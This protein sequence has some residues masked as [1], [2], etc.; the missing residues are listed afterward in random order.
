MTGKSGRSGTKHKKTFE[1]AALA[2]NLAATNLAQE[3]IASALKI[4]V[5]TLVKYYADELSSGKSIL[6][7]EA[8][9]G[10]RMKIAEGD[11][12]AII[13]AASAC[14]GMRE[15]QDVNVSGGVEVR[16]II[17]EKNVGKSGSDRG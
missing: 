12:R 10:L 8:V 13:F 14:G 5:E 16:L 6:A 15:K 4:S 11:T 9:E 17:G 7:A 2:Q 1:L 3:A